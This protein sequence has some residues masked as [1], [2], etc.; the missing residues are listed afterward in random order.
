V[1][2][3]VVFPDLVGPGDEVPERAHRGTPKEI[4]PGL[5]AYASAGVDHLVAA[6]T[7]STPEAM[8]ALGEAARLVR[9]TARPA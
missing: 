4:A 9:E 5:A 7:P 6:V 1:G 8:T 2:I 3:N